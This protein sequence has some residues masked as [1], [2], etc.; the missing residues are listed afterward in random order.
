[1]TEKSELTRD[2]KIVDPEDLKWFDEKKDDMRASY[3]AE[4]NSLAL[5]IANP[6][7]ADPR[8]S[9]VQCKM[10]KGGVINARP[11]FLESWAGTWSFLSDEDKEQAKA[12]G[13]S[14][15][16]DVVR[17]RAGG[18]LPQGLDRI[19]GPL[20][21]YY[22]DDKLL[23]PATQPAGLGYWRFLSTG[24]NSSEEIASVNL[25]GMHGFDAQP[26][27]SQVWRLRVIQRQHDVEDTS[28]PIALL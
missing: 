17:S 16:V 22:P 25:G 21:V 4:N 9:L 19:A 18:H 26:T 1:M 6:Q 8:R 3:F 14:E 12:M 23:N 27:A 10:A 24:F 20:V 7:V 15:L 2:I 13:Y 5:T 28:D 11:E